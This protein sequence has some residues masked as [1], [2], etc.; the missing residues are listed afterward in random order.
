MDKRNEL[1]AAIR[2]GKVLFD[3]GKVSGSS[4]NISFR[5]A[6]RFYI[7]ASGTCFGFLKEDDFSVLDIHGNH[8]KGPKPS[9]EWPLHKII[10]DRHK[11]LQAV[12]HTHSFYTVLWS[13]FEEEYAMFP[14]FTPYLDMKLGKLGYIPYYK[15]GSDELF[16][17]FRKNISI[18]EGYIL[19]NHG[20]IVGGE[21][22]EDAF[23]RI[24]EL[25]DS[26][27]VAWELKG[28]SWKESEKIAR[29]L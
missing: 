14:R 20:S 12:I 28:K 5:E 29:V 24:E 17:A 6:D 4:A 15:P 27:H 7:T 3:R 13:C 25:E 21:N 22:I 26:A 1:K 8:I 23:Y 16:E 11:H 10:Y 18:E 19:A 2:I 9:K